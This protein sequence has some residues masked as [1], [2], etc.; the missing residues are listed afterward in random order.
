MWIRV[1]EVVCL[2]V[3]GGVAREVIQR[4]GRIGRRRDE[5]CR[6]ARWA[7]Q[8]DRGRGER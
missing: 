6:R 7:K 4:L 5:V 1:I 2:L 8:R 3:A